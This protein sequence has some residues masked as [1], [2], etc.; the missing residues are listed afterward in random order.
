MAAS[1]NPNN[2]F[3]GRDITTGKWKE[4]E[5]QAYIVQEA[6]KAGYFIEGDQNA[7]KRGPVAAARAKACGMNAGTPDLRVLKKN[8]EIIFFELKLFGGKVS[9]PQEDWHNKAMSLGFPVYMV[10]ADTPKLAWDI[11]LNVLE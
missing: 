10:W 5:I 3:L 1:L 8:G 4:W 6:R 7:A 2:L 11:V 9:R